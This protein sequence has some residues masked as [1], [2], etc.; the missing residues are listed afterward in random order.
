MEI[1]I[2]LKNITEICHKIKYAALICGTS[3]CHM[4]VVPRPLF[5]EGVWGPYA[6]VLLPDYW[7]LEAGQSA[8]GKLLDH[9]ITSHPS[10]Q[11]LKKRLT[12]QSIH[13]EIDHILHSMVE[14]KKCYSVSRLTTNI[15]IWPD[16]HGNRS[17][18]ADPNLKGMVR[19]TK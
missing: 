12:Q 3:T 17:P 1:F 8:T 5:V 2:I 7:L 10:Y 14:S 9:I 11:S 15:H 6:D 19:Y 4:L 16:F 18:L 13:Q